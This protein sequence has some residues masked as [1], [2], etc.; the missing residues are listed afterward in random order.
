MD[1]CP[2]CN[3]SCTGSET[4]HRCKSDLKKFTDIEAEAQELLAMAVNSLKQR[5][6]PTAF[7][8]AKRS[9]GLKFSKRGKRLWEYAARLKTVSF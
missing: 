8:Q 4:C 7:A 9:C 2:I 5:D 6:Y 1:I 3:A